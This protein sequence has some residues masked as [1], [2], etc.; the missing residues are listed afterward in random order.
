[1]ERKHTYQ[2]VRQIITKLGLCFLS[3]LLRS[4][5]NL[6]PAMGTTPHIFQWGG[7]RRARKCAHKR[8]FKPFKNIITWFS[9]TIKG[10]G[11]VTGFIEHIQ[12]VT[13]SI[14]SAIANSHTLWSLL[15]DVLSL[16]SLPYLHQSLPN[17]GCQQCPLLPCSSS[18]GLATVPQLIPSLL[19]AISRL[20]C[21]CSWSSLYNLD[22]D[23]TENTASNIYSVIECYTAIT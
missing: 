23:R 4:R 8:T 5:C 15:Q 16:L 21:N 10:F 6:L 18:Y 7:G 19:T 20:P 12:I 17:H 2:W 22:T 14:Y 11:L 9:V 3:F 13:T 1:M